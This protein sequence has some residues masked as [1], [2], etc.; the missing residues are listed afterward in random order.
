MIQVMIANRIPKERKP[1]KAVLFMGYGTSATNSSKT[2][3]QQFAEVFPFYKGAASFY[4]S[5][6]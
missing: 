5:L 2:F 4:C 3:R 1:D 6:Q